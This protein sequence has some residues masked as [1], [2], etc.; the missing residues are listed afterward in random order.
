ME[1]STVIGILRWNEF[2]GGFWSI[3]PD[4]GTTALVLDGW[5]PGRE[6]GGGGGRG[7]T[8]RPVADGSHVR[9]RVREREEQFGFMMA[10][11]YVDV[12]ELVPT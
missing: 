3:E 7:D 11:T 12:L 4:D 10:G 8:G 5:S 2:E 9:A 6:R 1:A